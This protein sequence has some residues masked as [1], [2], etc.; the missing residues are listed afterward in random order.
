MLRQSRT[1]GQVAAM[2]AALLIASA[3]AKTPPQVEE[4]RL[5]KY[6]ALRAIAQKEY[7]YASADTAV[8]G[9]VAA[10]GDYDGVTGAIMKSAK[11]TRKPNMPSRSFEVVARFDLE[12]NDYPRLGMY[13]GANYVFVEH[14]NE[15]GSGAIRAKAFFVVPEKIAVM[16]YLIADRRLNLSHMQHPVPAAVTGSSKLL[17]NETVYA[18]CVEGSFCP[19]GHCGLTDVGDAFQ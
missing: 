17:S 15:N 9:D 7:S 19:G 13:K 18:A 6:D 2:Q 3:C 10:I 5:P 8:Q 14:A 4:M 12:G 16:H 1:L 11:A